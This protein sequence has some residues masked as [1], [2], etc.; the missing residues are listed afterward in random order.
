MFLNVDLL[1]DT[2]FKN[3]AHMLVSYKEDVSSSFI[4]GIDI[5]VKQG[6][7]LRERVTV[8]SEK[9]GRQHS[10]YKHPTFIFLFE[11]FGQAREAIQN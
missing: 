3:T 6:F 10:I 5:R 4:Y 1:R 2:Y 7:I 8:S 9:N 11:F